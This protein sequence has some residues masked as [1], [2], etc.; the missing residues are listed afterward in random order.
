MYCILLMDYFK[1][2]P[3]S[4]YQT[5]ELFKEKSR[6]SLSVQWLRFHNSQPRCPSRDEWINKMWHIHTMEYY[7]QP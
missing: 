4:F 3:I 5:Y 2:Q 6:T 1:H 7:T